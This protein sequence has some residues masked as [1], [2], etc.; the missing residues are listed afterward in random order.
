MGATQ[1]AEWER[2]VMS[3]L[4]EPYA[5]EEEDEEEI[6]TAE[7]DIRHVNTSGFT[8]GQGYGQEASWSYI[9]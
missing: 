7:E 9:H 8:T 3:R 2:E 5:C 6:K 1:A 4:C